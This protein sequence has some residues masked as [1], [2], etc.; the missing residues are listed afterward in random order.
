VLEGLEVELGLKVCDLPFPQVARRALE[1][2]WTRD[3]FD[4]LI[5][6]QASL[7]EAALVTKDRNILQHYGSALWE[8]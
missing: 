4:R 6:S 5:V 2:T 1:L 3:P 7:R 8:G